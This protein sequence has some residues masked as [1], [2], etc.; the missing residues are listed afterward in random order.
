ME[1]E[2][3]P[4]IEAE[5]SSEI[6]SLDRVNTGLMDARQDVPA[7]S[8]R[9]VRTP[10]FR[11]PH[12]YA[13]KA[14]IV[15]AVITLAV[16]L[17]SGGT[18][19][20]QIKQNNAVNNSA[21]KNIPEQ[22]VK[23][24]KA[25]SNFQAP[26][27]QG[28]AN[29]L[30]VTGDV[31]TRGSLK[32]TSDTFITSLKPE[33]LT[34][35]QTYA[36][37]NASGTVCLNINNCN[38]VTTAQLEQLQQT[39][40]TETN[41][42]IASSTP[43]TAD[44]GVKTLQGLSGSISL[45]GSTNQLVV[46]GSG[47][48]ISL[49]LPQDIALSSSPSFTGLTLSGYGPGQVLVGNGNGVLFGVAP[50]SGAQCLVSTSTTAVV[51]GSCVGGPAAATIELS[52]LSNVAI[53]TSL[54]SGSAT[55]DL[56]SGLNPFRDLYLGGTATNNFWISGTATAPRTIT[57]PDEDGTLCTTGSVCTGYQAAGNY[58]PDVGSANYIQ[59]QVGI[60]QPANFQ[61]QSAAP[62]NIGAVIKG[63]TD[64]TA[65]LFQLQSAKVPFSVFGVGEGGAVSIRNADDSA[66]A[67]SI[68]NASGYTILGVDSTSIS[69]IINNRSFDVD[70]AGW[71]YSGTPGSIAQTAAQQYSGAGS[72]MVNTTANTNNGAKYI[73]GNTN[74]TQ[75]AIN[76]T[77]DISWYDKLD[78]AEINPFTTVIAAY[79]VD[80]INEV[81][82]TD[83]NTSTVVT[84]GWTRHNCTII[85]D[86]TLPAANAYI[87]IKQSDA[88]ARTFYID[89]VQVA[90][91]FSSRLH[92]TDMVPM[93]A[94]VVSGTRIYTLD[95]SGA[96]GAHNSIQLGTDGLARI[97][98]YDGSKGNLKFLQCFND[99]CTVHTPTL[100]TFVDDGFN[101]TN[102]APD[103]GL[104][105]S[106][107]LD[108]NNLP[109][110][111]Y[112][113][114]SGLDLKYAACA[115]QDCSSGTS[116]KKL[117]IVGSV[118]R[119]SQIAIGPDG[120][121][122]II[123]F[124]TTTNTLK[125]IRCTDATCAAFV[126]D[127]AQTID[128]M[129]PVG[130]TTNG[131]SLY[132][133]TNGVYILYRDS[134]ANGLKF[135]HC[136]VSDPDCTS[137][138]ITPIDSPN[139]IGISVDMAVGSDGFARLAYYHGP[140]S[141]KRPNFVRCQNADCS[142]QTTPKIIDSRG[143]YGLAISI[144]LDAND[145]PRISY[146][147]NATGNGN[148][149]YA[150]CQDQNCDLITLPA[151]PVDST[152]RISNNT[153]LVITPTNLAITA[154][155][156]RIV[157]N[158]SVTGD[159]RYA[160]LNTDSGGEEIAGGFSLGTSAIPFN[161]LSV[162]SI[163]LQGGLVINNAGR[164]GQSAITVRGG[165][166]YINAQDES[167]NKN[168]LVT[169]DT[170][171]YFATNETTNAFQIGTYNINGVAQSI[172]MVNAKSKH[173]GINNITPGYD[174][175]ITGDLNLTGA[176]RID[177]V[178]ICDNAGCI[179]NGAAGIQNGTAIQSA[180]FAI[181]SKVAVDAIPDLAA[182]T[183]V[184]QR[185]TGQTGNLLQIQDESGIGMLATIAANGN[186][187][188]AGALSVQ[189]S[190]V[191]QGANALTLGTAGPAG[192]DGAV[193]FNNA[194]GGNT[195]TLQAPAV[196]PVGPL[197]FFLP[198]AD[199]GL[200]DCLATNGAGALSFS[201]C[202]G[203][204]GGSGTVGQ[205]AKFTAAG[206]IGDSLLSEAGSTLTNTGNMVIQGANTLTLGMAGPGGN[207]GA[208]I[209]QNDVG[210][211]TV[212]L[213]APA[214][215]PASP[216]TFFLPA[217]DG[218]GGDCLITD[219]SGALSF[220]SCT[221]GGGGGATAFVQ[222]G[223]SFGLAAELGTNDNFGLNLRTDG[224]T[225]LSIDTSG[226]AS[227]TGTLSVVTL[228]TADA[229]NTL[230]C[231][232][233]V[234][235]LVACS[236]GGGGTGFIQ[237]V[238]TTTLQNTIIPTTNSVVGLTVNGTS[239]TAA[240]AVDIIQSGNATA[241]NISSLGT[242][243][244]A[245][246]NAT[247]AT[248]NGISLAL[249]SNS[250][251][252]YALQITTDS[253]SPT[254]INAFTVRASGN[255]GIGT[256]SPNSTLDI[257]SSATN[258]GALQVQGNSLTSGDLLQLTNRES[259]F[260]GD[261]LEIAVATNLSDRVEQNVGGIFTNNTTEA[262]S[263]GGTVFNLLNT[264]AQG[265][266]DGTY[267][268]DSST[269]S[270]LNFDIVNSAFTTT[271]VVEYCS[272]NSVPSTACDTWS[273]VS[274]LDDGTF[275]FGFDGKMSWTNPGV[276]WITSVETVGNSGK[277]LRIRSSSS[278]SQ[279]PTV[280]FATISIATGNLL[281]LASNTTTK[282]V[283]TA[284]GN[285]GI[286]T[287]GPL[288]PLSVAGGAAI[289]SYAST[290]AAP[291]NGLIVSGNVGIGTVAPSNKLHVVQSDTSSPTSAAY[292]DNDSTTAGGYG[293][294]IDNANTTSTGGALRILGVAGA[295]VRGI[296]VQGINSGNGIFIGSITTGNAINVSNSGFTSGTGFN[297]A[298]NTTGLTSGKAI[299][300]SGTA[301]GITANFTG[302]YINVAPTRSMTANATRNDSGNVINLTP[303]Y[304]ITG[305]NAANYT[306]S[307]I[308]ANINRSAT[309][310]NS[311][312]TF[313]YSS[314]ATALDIQS[315]ITCTAGTC[316]DASTML[317]VAQ[318]F[319][320]STGTVMNVL[321]AGTGN[322]AV[323]DATNAS[324]N[325]LSVD[326]QSNSSSQYALDVR[327]NNGTS[328]LYV[329]A[330]GRVGIGTTGPSGDL[331][332]RQLVNGDTA[333]YSKRATDSGPTGNFLQLQ[334]ATNA[335]L[336]TID[337]AGNLTVKNAT[338]NGTLTVVGHFKSTQVIAPTIG[339]PTNCG[340]TP[341]AVVTAGSTD[342]AGSFTI[343]AGTAGPSTCDTVLTF[344]T[345][346]G[347]APK[348]VMLTSKS[349]TGGT[350]NIYISATS[351]TTFTTLFSTN[352]ADSETNS[353]Y[354]WVVE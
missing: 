107:A 240:T 319:A 344:N 288:S 46:S 287:A 64:Q 248:A 39:I 127:T 37:P 267:F 195:V 315:G 333:I 151:N 296:D 339:T 324:A 33:D 241:L 129:G 347:A 303:A 114:S 179:T 211:N 142:L 289:G 58:A 43:A 121:A 313:A 257:I 103:V 136:L 86:G 161:K 349:A 329:R 208:V 346:Y 192:V 307:G 354:Y 85:T 81:N 318:N 38:F 31:I 44:G 71:Q 203:G 95:S 269:F 36:L 297:F 55:I 353:Y 54:L 304:N 280:N 90:D 340:T 285:V 23:P 255:V 326:V 256:A 183:A 106:V 130:N 135:A 218:S 293:L 246:L 26:E 184:I 231:R 96:M 302:S 259:A 99:D 137:P 141:P 88:T 144:R 199:G 168:L 271:P 273:A 276:A 22:D 98:Y 176:Y 325:G 42:I 290:D 133:G 134:L 266:N 111:S 89:N 278:P 275:N 343:I 316:T 210:A 286:S 309:I 196:D 306:I 219:G 162:R 8:D 197:T 171:Q 186:I 214:G 108:P 9:I 239:G 41:T 29:S 69:N 213:Q 227:L 237:Q 18:V 226:N 277:W 170:F 174:L 230:L 312:A 201:A 178:K 19:F 200:G 34:A 50:T 291:S 190:A 128:S 105:N 262:N 292:I 250:F 77:Y 11:P 150:K 188:T 198:S 295:N 112:Y 322:L 73:T 13:R 244:L 215:D 350:R 317:N 154:N 47:S 330:D 97:A 193:V 342:S 2:P 51:F 6:E 279:A 66:T 270:A 158:D 232:N 25:V 149:L 143:D 16:L 14:I 338:I 252:N 145:W 87:S 334:D 68:Q 348:S 61:I 311:N 59:N 242:G 115:V 10:R 335:D 236:S 109:R 160:V 224:V 15:S 209:F 341:S 139:D 202:G 323:L 56:G 173:I 169:Q 245:V 153:G 305:T 265:A 187:F 253:S 216:L 336:A 260:S 337:I 300:I 263:G 52:N 48:T 118:G 132:V 155:A 152:T 191:I 205:I 238:P 157:Y 156:T 119:W 60:F 272:A 20:Y 301:S 327:S 314:T 1:I 113:D 233:S 57:L 28:A 159:L 204:V 100:N 126:A 131:T 32:V 148:L 321:G 65:D 222:G 110:I 101:G 147:N 62:G 165:G 308:L 180:N 206:T 53:N 282:L 167:D 49:T 182:P 117:A 298:T 83:Q 194:T 82:C 75:L 163:D 79:S 24:Q 4:N 70:A 91:P 225:R 249:E 17:M 268:M 212:T 166:I 93:A 351:T 78:P 63:A 35:N 283:V 320:T 251:N 140:A 247:N 254:P 172:F 281:K 30:L 125:F 45:L 274:G 217:A 177:G 229:T 138:I 261:A 181:S 243:N 76:T 332:I 84:T 234:N 3:N 120:Y 310:N 223:N 5:P 207:A 146:K 220:T 258:T 94:G 284:A 352:P 102:S 228:G 175:D 72:L 12:L 124:D 345:A 122:R 299:D 331:D 21:L 164:A 116:I 235:E 67:F 264:G 80:G 27:F 123:Y 7:S 92:V 185:V 40:I 189:G 328:R 74:P 104:F 221:G 294:T